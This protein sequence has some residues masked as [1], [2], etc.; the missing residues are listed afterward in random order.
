MGG[1]RQGFFGGLEQGESVP[2]AIFGGLAERSARK[3]ALTEKE[4][5]KRNTEF[6]TAID[7]LQKK[8]AAALK[9]DAKGNTIETPASLQTKYALTQALQAR[10]TFRTPLSKPGVGQKL[11]ELLRIKKKPQAQ[12]VTTQTGGVTIPAEPLKELPPEEDPRFAV[13]AGEPPNPVL[14]QR[15]GTAPSPE[16]QA[17]AGVAVTIPGQRTTVK[18]PALNAK[19]LREQAQRNQRVKEETELLT[20]AAPNAPLS[21]EQQA[22]QTAQAGMAGKME[23]IR[24]GLKA[25]RTFYPDASA[26]ELERLNNVYLDTQLGTLEKKAILKPLSGSKPYK[27]TDGKYYQLMQDTL[28]GEISKQELPEGYQP[29]P[30]KPGTSKFSVNVDSYRAMHNIP[31]EQKLTQPELNFIEQQIALSSSAPSTTITNTLKQDADGFWRPIQEANRRI[32]GFGVILGDPRGRVARPNRETTAAPTATELPPATIAGAAPP[33]VPTSP[34]AAKNLAAKQ[35]KR[36]AAPATASATAPRAPKAPRTVGG[37]GARGF[38][39]VRVGPKLF[40]APSKDYTAAKADLEGAIDRQNTMDRNLK[41]ALT[42]DQQA[43]ISLV[44]NH[45]GMTLGG[46]KGARINQAVWNEAVE[47]AKL[48]ERLLAKS[49][50]R[51]PNNGDYIFDGWKTGVT[52]TPAQMH[53]MVN[54]AHEKVAVLQAHV[55]RLQKQLGLTPQ[56][57]DASKALAD[58]LDKALGGK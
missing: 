41:A 29:P 49:F 33:T 38:G 55:A 54:L 44:S 36:P 47:S 35:F 15:T 6:D 40:A 46:Q 48:D 26:E 24:G 12:A 43:M 14:K 17:G 52:L 8:Y 31:P 23:T 27:G 3:Q 2:G 9:T 20:S 30:E 53:Q 51:D 4:R 39:G 13:P 1:F 19:Q 50:H 16:Q 5:Q 32:P 37:G 11:E 7:D 25:I 34:G 45:I 58:R 28:T 18:G 21:P 22:V 57:T 56:T 42:N 10:D